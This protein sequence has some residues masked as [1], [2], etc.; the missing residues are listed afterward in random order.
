MNLN[1]YNSAYLFLV[2]LEYKEMLLLTK[3]FNY[4]IITF[5]TCKSL[6]DDWQVLKIITFANFTTWSM[7]NCEAFFVYYLL[8]D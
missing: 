8:M 6:K 4:V 3:L 5:Q 7:W 1:S 2:K